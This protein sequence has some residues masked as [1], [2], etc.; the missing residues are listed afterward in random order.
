VKA[1]AISI[2]G[3]FAAARSNSTIKLLNI[4]TSAT[5]TDIQQIKDLIAAGNAATQKQIAD[6][7]VSTQKQIAD[8]AIV[9]QKQIADLDKKI[10]VGFAKI[11]GELKEVTNRL[12]AVESS[13]KTID[14][15]LWGLIATLLGLTVTALFGIFVRYLFSHDSIL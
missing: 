3:L 1:R 14:G 11:D 4:M 2:D 8:S 7:A 15:R 10:D 9:T 5:D 6:L 12:V 13:N